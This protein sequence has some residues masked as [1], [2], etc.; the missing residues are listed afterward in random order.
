MEV[1]QFDNPMDE[2]EFKNILAEVNKTICW[3]QEELD[4]LREIKG[5]SDRRK[6][7]IRKGVSTIR[8]VGE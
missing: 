6:K 4:R 8:E 7:Y 5:K 3:K 1:L 2:M